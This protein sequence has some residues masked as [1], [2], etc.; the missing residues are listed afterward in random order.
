[1]YLSQIVIQVGTNK[2]T[3]GIFF[4]SIFKNEKKWNNEAIDRQMAFENKAGV[5]FGSK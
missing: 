2:N 1:M 5:L 3:L 4:N